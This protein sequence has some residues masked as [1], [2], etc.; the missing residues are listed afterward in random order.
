MP[1]QLRREVEAWL[2]GLLGPSG[3]RD[4]EAG[5]A[6]GRC[7]GGNM[8]ERDGFQNSWSCATGVHCLHTC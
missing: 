5:P 7:E 3:G 1:P 2:R 6:A 8:G 4:G